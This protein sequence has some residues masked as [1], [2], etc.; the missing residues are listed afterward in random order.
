MNLSACDVDAKQATA[1]HRREPNSQ[2]ANQPSDFLAVVR[3]GSLSPV[4]L[5]QPVMD[6]T[7]VD[8]LKTSDDSVS[9]GKPKEDFRVYGKSAP[10][11][12]SVTRHYTLMRTNQTLEF[13]QRMEEK[14]RAACDASWQ[15]D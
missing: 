15:V 13:V 14:V 9:L 1:T 7:A 6:V 12:E 4:F 8:F 11:E 10:R 3:V 5:P 2:R